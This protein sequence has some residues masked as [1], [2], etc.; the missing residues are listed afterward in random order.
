MKIIECCPF[1][2]ENLVAKIHL[3]ENRKWV[4][5]F[6]ITECDR[7]FKFGE[8]KYYLADT[9]RN[10]QMVYYH[11]LDGNKYFKN[12]KAFPTIE[13]PKISRSISRYVYKDPSWRNEACQRNYSLW[14]CD[15]SDNDILIL[16]D[17]DEIIDSSFADKIVDF[18]KKNGIA[19]I[20]I[21]FTNFYFNLFCHGFGGPE[22]YSY[23]VFIV[24]GDVMRKRFMNDSDHL[25][26]LGE[27]GALQSSVYCFPQY[28]GFHHSWIGDWKKAYEKINSYAHSTSDHIESI[29]TN[30]I[31][32]IERIKQC[33]E[34]GISIFPNTTLVKDSSIR[35]LDVVNVVKNSN[36]ELFI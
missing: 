12:K 21:H 8:K 28:M 11:Q 32:D 15:Y 10:S 24:R 26:K 3:N 25:R 31:F 7:T 29:S 33:V 5:E 27:S 30:G 18:V 17:I 19:T 6:H 1:F 36:P 20:K 16:S 35:L 9:I 14:N 4:D 23:R 34:D 22:G 13:I 2:N